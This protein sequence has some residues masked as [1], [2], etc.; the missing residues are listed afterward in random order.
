[1]WWLERNQGTNADMP[2]VRAPI[3]W[4]EPPARSTRLTVDVSESSSLGDTL[5]VTAVD[6]ESPETSDAHSQKDKILGEYRGGRLS[7]QKTGY[8]NF[9]SKQFIPVRL[10]LS[11]QHEVAPKEVATSDVWQELGYQWRNLGAEQQEQWKAFAKAKAALPDTTL[12]LRRD[13]DESDVSQIHSGRGGLGF[14]DAEMPKDWD[15]GESEA[16]GEE[17]TKPHGGWKDPDMAAEMTTEEA[18]DLV[19]SIDGLGNVGGWWL[20]VRKNNTKIQKN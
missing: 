2:G 20:W 19:C 6:D 17:E 1:M 7:G 8:Q 14:A 3:K 18:D 4:N 10:G 16:E 12:V 15:D 11:E 9:V 13:N 5:S